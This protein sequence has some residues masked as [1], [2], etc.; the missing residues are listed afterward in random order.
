LREV[1]LQHHAELLTAAWWREQTAQV[2]VGTLP[3]TPTSRHRIADLAISS[4]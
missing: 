3:P 1:F 2:A 4:S